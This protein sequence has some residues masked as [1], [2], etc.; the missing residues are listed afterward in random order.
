[1]ENID[2]TVPLVIAPP[3]PPEGFALR[4]VNRNKG[5]PANEKQLEALR[6]AHLAMKE[7]RETIAKEKDERK[8]KGEPEP[9]PVVIPK[10]IVTQSYTY[11]KPKKVRKERTVYS[12]PL[13]QKVSVNFS[14]AEYNQIKEL[15]N[16]DKN[17]VVEK[18]VIREVVKEIPTE[19]IVHT[20]KFLTGSELLNKIFF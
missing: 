11:V 19:K 6:K 12:T 20:E 5:T 1:M 7:K 15:L 3:V 9:P 17:P 16:K 4:K 2:S 8:T 10:K 13:V 18:E 14:E